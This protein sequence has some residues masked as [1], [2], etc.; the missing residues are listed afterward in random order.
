MVDGFAECFSFRTMTIFH[1]VAQEDWARAEILGVYCAPSLA[2]EGFIHFSTGQQL[3]R[4]AERFYSGR[5]D[6]IAIMVREDRLTAPLRFEFAHG[7]SFPHLYGALNLDAVLE[8]LLLPRDV[9]GR[10]R[11]PE[12][13]VGL[14]F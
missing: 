14:E 9:D 3:L 6:M 1:L 11:I 8:V 2:S 10:F 4:S 13:W 12:K 5:D 7:E